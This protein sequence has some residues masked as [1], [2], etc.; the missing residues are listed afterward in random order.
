MARSAGMATGADPTADEDVTT[1]DGIAGDN[2]LE[3]PP[4]KTRLRADDDDRFA[5]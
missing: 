5:T 1:G 4:I 2:K 3:M